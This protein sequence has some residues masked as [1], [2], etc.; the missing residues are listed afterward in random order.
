MRIC[1]VTNEPMVKGYVFN[2][3]DVYCKF[4]KDAID[5]ARENYPEGTSDNDI[6]DDLYNSGEMYYTEWEDA[7][8]TGSLRVSS[9]EFQEKYL[10]IL[11]GTPAS[12][13]EILT[14][15]HSENFGVNPF[16]DEPAATL[17]LDV[18]DIYDEIKMGEEVE[19]TI[20]KNGIRYTLTLKNI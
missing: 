19:M 14:F 13:Q 5:M 20:F 12:L 11:W 2:D 3:G 6:L 10:S 16:S 4:K 15:I 8:V 17:P 7:M 18:T 9:K 1:T